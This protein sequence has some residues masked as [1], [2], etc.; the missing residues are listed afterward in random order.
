[1][2]TRGKG[3]AAAVALLNYLKRDAARKVIRAYGYEF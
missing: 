3:N 2:L 1:M